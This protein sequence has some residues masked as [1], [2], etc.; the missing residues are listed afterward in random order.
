MNP[1]ICENV[2]KDYPL[3]RTF[4]EFL[5]APFKEKYI[6]ALKGV[7]FEVAQGEIFVLIGPN[8]AGKTTLFK[9]IA[10]LLLPDKG[11]VT[12]NGF[13]VLKEESKVRKSI[14]YVVNEER[15][16]YW[17]LSGWEN[18]KFFAVLNNLSG[19]ELKERVSQVVELTGLGDWISRPVKDYSTGLRQR[20]SLARGLLV[21]PSLLILDEPTRSLDPIMA[22]ELRRF[23]K[24]RVSQDGLTVLLSTHNL[25][26]AE[27]MG[28]R[29]AI[30][31][32]GVIKKIGTIEEIKKDINRKKRYCL[33]FSV[34][35]GLSSLDITGF[36][37]LGSEGG[38]YRAE[39]LISEEKL[40]ELLRKILDKG[41]KISEVR[42]KELTLEESFSRIIGKDMSNA[43]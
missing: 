19:K 34:P 40:N 24:E 17:R 30:I 43:D 35:G 6:K 16:F 9:I 29:I 3:P 1:V 42:E 15:S 8:G 36:S 5:L 11:K 31:D 32:K 21:S 41:G 38:K 37:L 22:K 28:G 13:D 4:K 33:E 7:S 20:L 25:N 23:V 18:L 2:V 10:T 26:E 12:V 39:I 14:G 27:E